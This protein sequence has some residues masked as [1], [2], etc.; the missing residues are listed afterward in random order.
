[1]V[2]W[3]ALTFGGVSGEDVS[4]QNGPAR[5]PHMP[6]ELYYPAGDGKRGRGGRL[7]LCD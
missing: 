5:R 3:V 4:K 2:T 1:M 6:S 7:E